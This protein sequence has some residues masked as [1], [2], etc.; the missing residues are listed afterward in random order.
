MESLLTS[1]EDYDYII[2]M[3]CPKTPSELTDL[4]HLATLRPPRTPHDLRESFTDLHE[5]SDRA[6]VVL[7]CSMYQSPTKQEVFDHFDQ[8]ETRFFNHL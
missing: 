2:V 6:L 3:F 8:S 4:K 5:S 7:G 1:E